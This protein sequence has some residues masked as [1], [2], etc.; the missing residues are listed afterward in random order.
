MESFIS[1]NTMSS[2]GEDCDGLAKV[3]GAIESARETVQGVNIYYV[4]LT[5]RF[6]T[7]V[8]RALVLHKQPERPWLESY[9]DLPAFQGAYARTVR[10]T[11]ESHFRVNR[12]CY[13]VSFN[14]VLRHYQQSIPGFIAVFPI[15]EEPTAKRPLEDGRTSYQ[16]KVMLPDGNK[17]PLKPN[18][19]RSPEC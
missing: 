17:I 13:G 3:L 10:R 2:S 12:R 9:P 1:A 18:H 5:K 6:A 8:F 4:E 7:D 15:I 19:E 14:S 11:L 16:L